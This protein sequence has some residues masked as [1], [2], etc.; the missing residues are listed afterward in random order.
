MCLKNHFQG[1]QAVA[2]LDNKNIA[3]VIGHVFESENHKTLN[4]FFDKIIKYNLKI[5][6]NKL[7]P[8]HMGALISLITTDR[9]P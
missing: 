5:I 7:W 9:C 6:N 1:I 8:P 3:I 2:A 4:S